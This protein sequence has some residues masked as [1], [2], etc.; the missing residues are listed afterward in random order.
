MSLP[1]LAKCKKAVGGCVTKLSNSLRFDKMKSSFMKCAAKIKPTPLIE[2]D[3]EDKE[4]L[5]SQFRK[6]LAFLQLVSTSVF[7]VCLIMFQVTQKYYI[8][9]LWVLYIPDVL[10]RKL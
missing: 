10:Y 4:T 6:E 9:G 1:P 3:N 7:V 5:K 8:R 2:M